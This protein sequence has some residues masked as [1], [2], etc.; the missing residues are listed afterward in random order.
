MHRRWM[1]WRALLAT[2]I[3]AVPTAIALWLIDGMYSYTLFSMTILSACAA[4]QSMIIYF[5]LRSQSQPTTD[6]ARIHYLELFL[7]VSLAASHA[8]S[9]RSDSFDRIAWT[10][11]SIVLAFALIFEPF[12]ERRRLHYS[13]AP[14]KDTSIYGAATGH[15]AANSE[16]GGHR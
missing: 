15:D 8:L 9:P 10:A 5:R 12:I 6:T 7:V 11:V 2:L 3:V 14:L 4:S 13:I 16:E 1:R